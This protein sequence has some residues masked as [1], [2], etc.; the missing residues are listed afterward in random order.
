MRL[1]RGLRGEFGQP[2]RRGERRHGRRR[3]GFHG[4]VEQ[5]A[6]R[7]FL[8][9]LEHADEHVV[10]FALVLHQRITLRHRPQPDALLEVV[11]LVEVLTPLA[12]KNVEQHV[13]FQLPHRAVAGDLLELL[14]AFGVRALGVVD[15]R[16]EQLVGDGLGRAVVVLGPPEL[17]DLVA[18]LLGKAC[19]RQRDVGEDG[20][21]VDDERLALG[22]VERVGA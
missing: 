6:H 15:Q 20:D 16:V 2:G 8:E 14:L 10:A 21:H 9:P 3:R 7:L 17:V 13:A 11:H 4:D 12:V 18:Q 22:T 19:P 5:E 1:G